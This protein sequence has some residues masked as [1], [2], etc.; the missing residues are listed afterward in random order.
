MADK[1]QDCI[2]SDNQREDGH[3]DTRRQNHECDDKDPNLGCDMGI[4]AAG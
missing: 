3:A 2:E 1:V 4:D